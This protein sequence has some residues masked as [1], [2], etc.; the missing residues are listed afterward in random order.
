MTVV[1]LAWLAKGGRSSS[2]GSAYSNRYDAS[3]GSRGASSYRTT[4]AGAYGTSDA[5]LYGSGAESYGTTDAGSS[6]AG[7]MGGANVSGAV[8]SLQNATS[9]TAMAARRTTRRV[10]NQFQRALNDNPLMIGLAA[11]MIGAA[12]G[13]ALPETESENRLVGDT[14]DAVVGQAQEMARG[15]ANRVEQAASDV[16]QTAGEIAGKVAKSE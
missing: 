10:Q 2:R 12:I 11:A 9:Q 15:V 5:D 3:Y 13:A 16:A 4:G 7:V 1:G 6:R 14:R 8:E